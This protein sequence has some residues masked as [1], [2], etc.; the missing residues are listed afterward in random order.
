M[1]HPLLLC[2]VEGLLSGKALLV[3]D[4]FL[5]GYGLVYFLL[6][7]HNLL[8]DFILTR[9]NLV[10]CLRV[11]RVGFGLKDFK[12]FNQ[13]AGI[14]YYFLVFLNDNIVFR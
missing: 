1:A 2:V 9:L 6:C 11:G 8:P 10:E 7:R 3:A 13:V 12:C 4:G 5:L 14:P